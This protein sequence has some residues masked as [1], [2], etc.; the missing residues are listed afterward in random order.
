MSFGFGV[1]DVIAVAELAWKLYHFCF[2]VSRGAPHEFQLLLQQITS[3]SQSLKL[4]QLEAKNPT[5]NLM[6]SGPDRIQMVGEIM[7]RV[8]NTLA[9]LE[10]F[11]VKYQKMGD[12][13]HPQ[14]NLIDPGIRLDVEQ[15]AE[16]IRSELEGIDASMVLLPS[17][18]QIHACDLSIWEMQAKGAS[19]Q[20][21]NRPEAGYHS[22]ETE[23]EH[24][25]FRGFAYYR[26]SEF[27]T[28]T[29]CVILF[30]A[31]KR[32][33]AA[34]IVL[35]DQSWVTLATFGVGDSHPQ[36]RPVGN[37][38]HIGDQKI[39][40]STT[41]E[42]MYICA[43]ADA[44]EE[45]IFHCLRNE[46]EQATLLVLLLLFAIKNGYKEV[47]EHTLRG[48][49]LHDLTPNK[50]SSPEN[51]TTV[52]WREASHLATLPI[53]TVAG[54]SD[55]A[56]PQ[57][58]GLLRSLLFWGIQAGNKILATQLMQTK[59][60]IVSE[61][62]VLRWAD[63]RWAARN[64]RSDL[65]MFILS[66]NGTT[67]DSEGHLA[68]YLAACNGHG[69]LVHELLMRGVVDDHRYYKGL[70]VLQHAAAA[71]NL[72]VVETIIEAGVN[73]NDPASIDGNSALPG[74]AFG[75]HLEVVEVLLKAGADVNATVGGYDTALQ[76][77]AGNGHKGVIEL[78][79]KAGADVN[80]SAN[81][82]LTPLQNASRWGHEVVVE[83]LLKVGADINASEGGRTALKCAARGGTGVIMELL[84][85]AGA[86]V[87]APAGEYHTALQRGGVELLLKAGADVNAPAGNY[88]TALQFAI[89][90]GREAV[91]GLLLKAGADVNAPP[92]NYGTALQSAA[93]SGKK[94]IVESLLQAGADVNVEV[95]GD[96]TVLQYAAG[97][98]GGKDVVE[99]L[100]KAGADVNAPAGEYSTA[101]QWAAKKKG[102]KDVVELLLKAG[103]NVNAPAGESSTALQ[104]AANSGDEAVVELLLNAGAGVNASAGEYGT[105]LQCAALK[106]HK[107]VAEL[108]LKARAIDE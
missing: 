54:T 60:I 23:D 27:A 76:A 30:V 18:D 62:E 2:V 86:D 88:C 105:A 32:D 11:A 94:G 14:F 81:G 82:T 10:K 22:W 74:A 8:K 75:G 98:K 103:A 65:V 9:E 45:Y 39:E 52:I 61:E 95:R 101:L 71:R 73:I 89:N 66:E 19:I 49:S 28:S 13:S 26:P 97:G 79:L 5:S 96:R 34:H 16:A 57:R 40:F 68:Y 100:L 59:G 36:P 31:H 24:V 85:K 42:A 58:T 6:S 77:A 83:L 78:L 35:G 46:N 17:S 63:L 69:D 43:M 93:Y 87:N 108:L 3:L 12:T 92:G 7:A 53:P 70:T 25:L 80:A 56:E 21:G 72:M 106:G 55:E 20:P 47:V 29:P 48:H 51:P 4:L 84:L 1:G 67:L 37:F 38:T 104:Y 50:T 102:G 41:R 99:L 107:G 64:G 44:V 91:V 90:R 33:K 15:L